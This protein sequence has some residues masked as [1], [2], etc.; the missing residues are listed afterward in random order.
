MS[1][2]STAFKDEIHRLAE[3]AFHRHL[4]SGYGDSE[5]VDKYQIVYQGKPRHLTLRN[6]YAFLSDL[7]KRSRPV[8]LIDR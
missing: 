1:L 5:Y 4:I 3:D 2:S 8:Q 7:I 6:A